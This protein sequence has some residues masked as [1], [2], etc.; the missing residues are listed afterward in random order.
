MLKCA[1]DSKIEVVGETP[2]SPGGTPNVAPEFFAP[3]AR[4][5]QSRDFSQ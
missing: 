2:E 4:G 3:V 5:W 1:V